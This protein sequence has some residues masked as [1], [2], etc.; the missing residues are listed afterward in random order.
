MSEEEEIKDLK[1]YITFAEKKENFS[2][3]Y[4]YTFHKNLAIKISRIISWYQRAKEESKEVWEHCN[5]NC[6]PKGTINYEIAKIQKQ[7][8]ENK[9]QK[10]NWELVEK[11]EEQKELLED[12]LEKGLIYE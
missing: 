4:E 2:N 1:Q 11:L 8:D 6:I 10:Q 12:I 5:K 9:K 7:I 3:F